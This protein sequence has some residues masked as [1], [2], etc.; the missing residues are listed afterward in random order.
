MRILGIALVVVLA[1]TLLTFVIS[2]R[3][4]KWFFNLSWRGRLMFGIPMFL[5]VPLAAVLLLRATHEPG[6]PLPPP[7]ATCADG[8]GVTA[9]GGD[10]VVDIEV[11]HTS[12]VPDGGG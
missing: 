1:I 7:V 5:I 10:C 8:K 4:S 6:P 9:D 11:L 3:A 2:G 12:S